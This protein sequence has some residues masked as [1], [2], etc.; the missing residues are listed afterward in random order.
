MMAT[1]MDEYHG[2]GGSYLVDK[3][4]GKR[5]LIQRTQPAP[6]LQSEVTDDAALHPETPDPGG[7]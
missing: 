5:K 3:K 4:T 1:M 7:D 2:Q 6:T